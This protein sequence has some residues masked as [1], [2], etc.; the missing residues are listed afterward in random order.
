MS[1][2][3]PALSRA[4][5]QARAVACQ[6]NLKQWGL[7][8]AMYC[9]DNNGCFFSGEGV[10]HGQY[11]RDTMRPYAKNVKMWLC[12]QATK[13]EGGGVPTQTYRA[14]K[15][16]NDVGSY[17]LNGWVLNPG[18]FVWR[19]PASDYWRTSRVK[20]ASNIPVFTDMWYVDAWP[21]DD[22]EEYDRETGPGDHPDDNEM[23]RV[24]VNRHDGFIKVLFMDWSVRRIGLKEL[25]TL[26]WH[27]T[28][29]TRN[30]HTI[31]GGAWPE[32][33]EQWMRRFKDY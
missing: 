14:W 27:K 10:G 15:Y 18:N 31:A 25:W 3:M 16:Q 29:N 21:R 26:K 32:D 17:G 13:A 22:D 28:F 8:Y 12:P 6:S 9:D 11:W 4:R 7:S 1:I 5:K 24:C 33:W 20:G 2:L 30:T 19:T 23:R